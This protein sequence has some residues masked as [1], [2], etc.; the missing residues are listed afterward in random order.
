MLSTLRAGPRAKGGWLPTSMNFVDLSSVFA[1]RLSFF[2]RAVFGW[3]RPQILKVYNE[4]LMDLLSPSS[5]PLRIHEDPS[6]GVVVVAG[7]T[8]MVRVR[9]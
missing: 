5:K 9:T 2:L 3:R 4:Q 6:K 1:C 7:L 8:E